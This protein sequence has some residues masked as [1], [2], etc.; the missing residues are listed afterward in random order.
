MFYLEGYLLLDLINLFTWLL[1]FL[2]EKKSDFI[3]GGKIYPRGPS[4]STLD[5]KSVLW[6]IAQ[7]VQDPWTP[8]IGVLTSHI[9]F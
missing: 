9:Y 6:E 1:T 3:S 8:N 2:P 7:M 4:P 5:N